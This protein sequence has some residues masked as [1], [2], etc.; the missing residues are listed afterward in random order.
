MGLT[1]IRGRC[2]N[3]SSASL[4]LANWQPE[5]LAVGKKI[6]TAFAINAPNLPNRVLP[7]ELNIRRARFPQGLN[8]NIALGFVTRSLK[9]E[10]R[11]ELIILSRI[12]SAIIEIN[13]DM[14]APLRDSWHRV[15]ADNGGT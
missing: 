4:Q 15:F 5:T 6:E 11:N 8:L 10:E 7:F 1:P 9:I 2:E 14:A 12:K 3:I 13:T